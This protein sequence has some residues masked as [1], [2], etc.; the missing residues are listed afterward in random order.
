[1]STIQETVENALGTNYTRQYRPHVDRVVNALVEREQGIASAV[2]DAAADQGVD[3]DAAVGALTDA[4][5][6]VPTTSAD[7]SSDEVA[8]LRQQVADLTEFARRNGYRG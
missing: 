3:Q 8:S 7:A 5:M 4:G 1:M 6:H 2:L